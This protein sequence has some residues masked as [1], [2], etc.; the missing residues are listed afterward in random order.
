M[1]FLNVQC[2]VLVAGK[3]RSITPCISVM[4]AYCFQVIFVVDA[5]SL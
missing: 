1:V 2:A 3:Q 4:F 5:N